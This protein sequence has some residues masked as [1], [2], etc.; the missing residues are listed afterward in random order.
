MIAGYNEKSTPVERNAS[1]RCIV[2]RIAD[3]QRERQIMPSS[4]GV[5]CVLLHKKFSHRMQIAVQ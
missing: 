2:K 4:S 1:H 3:R 5:G